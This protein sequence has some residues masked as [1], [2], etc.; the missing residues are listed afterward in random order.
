MDPLSF[1]ELVAAKLRA[2]GYR[3]ER[4]ATTNDWGVDIFA[5]RDAE[6]IAVQVKK[7]RG[8]RP[9]N[10]QMV[11]ELYGASRYFECTGAMIATDGHLRP[12][13][14]RAADKLGVRILDLD[15]GPFDDE[16]APPR[17]TR[18]VGT[19]AARPPGANFESIW[20]TYVMPLAGR[21]LA[22][23]RGLT[24]RILGVD[25]GGVRR[26]S[27]TGARS[28]IPIEPFRWAVEMILEFGE[29]SR[30]EI[31]EQY[32]GRASSG[33][34]LILA[35]VPLFEVLTVRGRSVIRLRPTGA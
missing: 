8:A 25:W 6:R 14:R 12:D 2:E 20:R 9:V 5:T 15:A 4:T 22:N 27:S 10:R 23:E 17:Q 34:Q 7:Y 28:R 26:V 16:L 21:T 13:A 29:V 3:T 1:E 11:F 32:A 18:V 30:Q 19:A 33:I 31:N 35:Q 24:N